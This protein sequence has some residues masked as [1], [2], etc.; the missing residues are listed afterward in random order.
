MKSIKKI[1]PL[2][3]FFFFLN[4]AYGFLCARTAEAGM[5]LM[6]CC[7]H[8]MNQSGKV[9]RAAM[10]NCCSIESQ[11]TQVFSKSDKV[12]L[13]QNIF[14]VSHANEFPVL[15]AQAQNKSFRPLGDW[16]HAPPLYVLKQS[17]L[18]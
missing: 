4:V 7:H 14:A 5:C 15:S 6:G 9:V 17:F 1:V 16:I 12:R 11:N 10:P 18:L 3:L 2:L 13:G 8:S